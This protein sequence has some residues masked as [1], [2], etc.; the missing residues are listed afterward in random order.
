M[1]NQPRVAIVGGPD[2][3]ARLPLLRALRADFELHAFGADPALAPRFAAEGFPFHA[4]PLS[5]RVA[6]LGDV[7]TVTALARAF[8]TT[9]PDVVHAFDTKPGVFASIAARRAGVP[10]V[11]AT[12]TGLGS[13]YGGNGVK[14]RLLRRIYETL[15]RAASRRADLTVFQNHDD[16]DQLVASRIVAPE[17]TAVIL[18]SGVDTGHFAR[19]RMGAEARGRVRAELGLAA[20]DVVVTLIAR[21]TRSKGIPEFVAAATALGRELPRA[22]FLLVGP[23]DNDSL[24]RLDRGELAALRAAVQ[25]PGRRDDVPAVL[26]ATDV[27]VLP[28]AYRE[29]VPR[30]L[31]EA[32]AMGLPLVAT[33]SPG[34]NEVVV[35]GENG[36]LV[37]VGDVPALIAALR[38][39]LA[40]AALRE[41]QGA[42]SRRRVVEH[43][44]L[45]VVADQT[46]RL[47]LR[48]LESRGAAPR[49][50]APS[51]DRCGTACRGS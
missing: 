10:V 21:V 24:D 28:T 4:Y 48:L 42:A 49:R 20:D 32:G 7:R 5:R 39:L 46:R 50:S 26:A 18:G 43:F 29:G 8:R 14:T 6:P 27:F 17:R 33:D 23:E 16:L 34:C 45:R 36:R 25:W 3:D 51:A 19:E 41:R 40:D 2:V 30:V 37:P 9:R 47:W 11:V 44:D 22:R 35:D 31:L 12:V 1:P 38:P 13:L 15:Q